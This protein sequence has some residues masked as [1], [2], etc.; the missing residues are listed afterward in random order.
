MSSVIHF[1]SGSQGFPF[2]IPPSTLLPKRPKWGIGA[3]WWGKVGESGVRWVV[4]G[5]MYNGRS[6][7]PLQDS[8]YAYP[9]AR[10]LW[11][12]HLALHLGKPSAEQ[13]NISRAANGL[14]VPG[15]GQTQPSHYS[16]FQSPLCPTMYA[17]RQHLPTHCAPPLRCAIRPPR[18]LC[19]QLTASPSI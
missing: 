12:L 7:E 13:S 15:L 11:E 1:L 18:R 8:D 16:P 9:A 19:L 10:A 6:N 17:H 2:S 3:L 14:L 5:N 4:V